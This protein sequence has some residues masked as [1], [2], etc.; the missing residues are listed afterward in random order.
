M[1]SKILVLLILC[2]GFFSLAAQTKDI[3]IEKWIQ[4]R[5]LR[6]GVNTNPYEFHQI[7]DSPA[8]KGYK[9]FY[10]S[11]YG[12]H[13]SRSD[14]GNKDYSEVI[15]VLSEA[16]KEG[17][18][19]PEGETL[20]SVAEKVLAE[21]NGM[22]GRL[23]PRGAREHQKIAERMYLR[24]RQVFQKKGGRV[25][26]VSSYVPRCLISMGAFTSSL[27]A[28]KPDLSLTWDAGDKF[29]KYLSNDCPK[30]VK[31][32]SEPLLNSLLKTSS[33]D[34]VFFL[35][36]IFTEPEKA[37][38]MISNRVKFQKRIFNTAKIAGSFDIEA[39]AFNVLPLDVILYWEQYYAAVLYL[40][41]CNSVEYGEEVIKEARPLLK[42]ILDKAEEA[43]AGSDVMADLRFGHDY[44][45]LSL[46]SLMGLEGIGDKMTY[47][48]IG[49]GW[50]GGGYTCFA[51]NIQMILYKNKAGDVL[52]KFLLNEKETLIIGHKPYQG[53]YYRWEDV[54]KI[55]AGRI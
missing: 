51:A 10:I 18:L 39:D 29:Q 44:P 24:Y 41:H 37:A 8:P 49:K 27:S 40:R 22:D 43:V 17:L 15:K 20:L 13:G 34:T 6:A 11:H 3:S 53:P 5:P 45:I 47:R 31:E 7:Y 33:P 35:K 55:F 48:E 38:P 26:A 1:K 23:T 19:T 42:D 46:G 4:E 9:P 21:Y 30:S 16:K 50:F 32:A 12:R 25:R 52:V 54:R 14:W 28:L 36:K 2:A